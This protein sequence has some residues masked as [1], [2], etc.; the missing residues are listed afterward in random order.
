MLLSSCVIWR[1]R[2]W[3]TFVSN[4][5]AAPAPALAS[6][7]C[8]N[9]SMTHR[10]CSSRSRRRGHH[11][12]GNFRTIGKCVRSARWTGPGSGLRGRPLRESAA[13]PTIL[14]TVV[15]SKRAAVVRAHPPGGSL[16]LRANPLEQWRGMRYA[17]SAAAEALRRA[18]RFMAQH[19]RREFQRSGVLRSRI[20]MPPPLFFFWRASTTSAGDFFGGEV[21]VVRRTTFLRRPRRQPVRAPG[22]SLDYAAL[23]QRVREPQGADIVALAHNT[24]GPAELPFPAPG[25]RARW[26]FVSRPAHAHYR[27]PAHRQEARVVGT[28]GLLRRA[29]DLGGYLTGGYAGGLARRRSCSAA[30][31]RRV[32]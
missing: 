18:Q 20:S 7:W 31:P 4:A 26:R 3:A 30:S 28:N 6:A 29:P 9:N 23:A 24:I 27:A 14:A 17:S 1:F 13:E 15:S 16:R 5:S 2:D 32:L 25:G 11:D 19:A 10:L 21:V 22:H 12:T 8:G